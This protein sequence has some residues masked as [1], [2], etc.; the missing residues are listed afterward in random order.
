MSTYEQ[1]NSQHEKNFLR[2]NKGLAVGVIALMLATTITNTGCSAKSAESTTPK[3]KS[4]IEAEKGGERAKYIS[5]SEKNYQDYLKTLSPEQLAVRESLGPDK[6]AQMDKDQLAEAFTIHSSEVVVDGKI[7]PD[8]YAEALTA[9]CQAMFHSGLSEKEYAKWGGIDKT[10]KDTIVQIVDNYFPIESQAL[11]GYLGTDEGSEIVLSVGIA[12]DQIMKSGLSPKPK[13]RYHMRFTVNP[14]SIK[15]IPSTGDSY[16]IQF[17]VHKSDNW[18]KDIMQEKASLTADPIDC[19]VIWNISGVHV[20]NDRVIT[21][22][23][24]MG[25]A[26]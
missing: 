2:S 15:A 1:N 7:D 9:R 6:L 3:S 20:D 13:E 5:E 25:S 23:A 11:L 17:S 24:N 16:D 26:D 18:E 14:N 8:L 21:T 22:K 12:V 19:D 10:G 4:K